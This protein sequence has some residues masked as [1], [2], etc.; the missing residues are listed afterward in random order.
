MPS[1][2]R[3]HPDPGTQKRG[4]ELKGQE[5]VGLGLLQPQ[6]QRLRKAEQVPAPS[7]PGTLAHTQTKKSPREGFF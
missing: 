5:T 4:H 3:G 6:E 1:L 2:T 7:R